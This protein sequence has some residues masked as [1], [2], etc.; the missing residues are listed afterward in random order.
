MKKGGGKIDLNLGSLFNK[1]YKKTESKKKQ[2]DCCDNLGYSQ[3][4]LQ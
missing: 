1:S 4:K 3:F 2:D